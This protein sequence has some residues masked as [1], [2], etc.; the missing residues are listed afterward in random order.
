VNPDI[1]LREILEILSVVRELDTGEG[2]AMGRDNTYIYGTLHKDGTCGVSFGWDNDTNKLY[3]K[4]DPHN[5]PSLAVVEALEA[6]SLGL[7]EFTKRSENVLTKFE[8]EAEQLSTRVEAQRVRVARFKAFVD[9]L[10]PP[11]EGTAGPK[12]RYEREDDP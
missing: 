9:R 2:Y 6:L 11:A 4:V 5:P 1:T 7:R 10:D 3:G 12:T 8:K